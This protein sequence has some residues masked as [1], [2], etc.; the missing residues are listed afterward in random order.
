MKPIKF[1]GISDFKLDGTVYSFT[2]NVFTNKDTLNYYN[3]K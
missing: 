1:I 2:K 3:N